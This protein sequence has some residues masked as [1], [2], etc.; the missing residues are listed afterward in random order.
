MR[1]ILAPILFLSF[2]LVISPFSAAH[3][4]PSLL[5]Y[6]PAPNPYSVVVDS[7]GTA[8]FTVLTDRLIRM[9]QR[10]ARAQTFEDRSTLAFLNR[11]LPTIAFQSKEDGGVLTI[12]TKQL[13]L[14]YTVGQPFA[15]NTLSVKSD[16]QGFPWSWTFGDANSG[17]L[18]GTI[19]GLDQ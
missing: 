3:A 14:S 5:P 9:E 8:R 17:N 11:N 10:G 15:P 1:S 7:S 18:L 16:L 19:R 13:T 6:N 4:R 12:S 2:L